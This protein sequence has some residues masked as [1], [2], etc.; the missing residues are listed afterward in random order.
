MHNGLRPKVSAL[1][2]GLDLGR[3]KPNGDPFGVFGAPFGAPFGAVVLLQID[4]LRL[5]LAIFK[6]CVVYYNET[7]NAVKIRPESIKVVCIDAKI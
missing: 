6:I 7:M 1:S 5:K 3:P 4:L 2:L